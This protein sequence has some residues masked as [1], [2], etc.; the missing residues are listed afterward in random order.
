MNLVREEH[1]KPGLDAGLKAWLGMRQEL[2][3]ARNSGYNGEMTLPRGRFRY[4]RYWD[5]K[6]PFKCKL[7]D[8]DWNDDDVG[9]RPWQDEDRD[10]LA[11][12]DTLRMR[13]AHV[14]DDVAATALNVRHERH[15]GWLINYMRKEDGESMNM[16]FTV[17]QRTLLATAAMR[18]DTHKVHCLLMAGANPNVPDKDRNTALHLALK[19]PR[20][21]HA[22]ELLEALLDCGADTEARNTKGQTPL[23]V[24]CIIGNVELMEVLLRRGCSVTKRDKKKKM[25]VEYALVR[26][27]LHEEHKASEVEVRAI[28]EQYRKVLGN[29]NMQ[30]M[31][32]RVTARS[33]V[34]QLMVVVIPTCP[35]CKR[36]TT[37]CGEI[38]RNNYR[39]WLLIHNK[40][41]T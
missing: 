6:L 13:H 9:K 36:K 14:T 7:E 41:P 28:F 30:R 4:K 3:D 19:E 18:G 24:A 16:R 38:R 37:T 34:A 25:A 12:L 8:E 32:S 10:F 27:V 21:F 40:V 29:R 20:R 17:N 33:F 1:F 35:K 31:W 15:L 26:N 11:A 39:H 22:L 2:R 23:H 5:L